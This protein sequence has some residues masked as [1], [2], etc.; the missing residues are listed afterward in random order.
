MAQT[1]EQ[2][3]ALEK[4]QRQFASDT[5]GEIQMKKDELRD[6]LC[7]TEEAAE[8]LG[9]TVAAVKYHVHVAHNLNPMRIGRSLVYTREQLDRFKES[10]R[11][12]GRPTK[13]ESEDDN[14]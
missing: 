11:P 12:Q 9:M 8:Y 7:S 5:F 2:R 6:E 4:L 10:K 3:A 14:N 13:E 1:P